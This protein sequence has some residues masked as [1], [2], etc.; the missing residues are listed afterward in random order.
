MFREFIKCIAIGKMPVSFRKFNNLYIT[1][2]VLIKAGLSGDFPGQDNFG[3]CHW[4]SQLFKNIQN[5]I[6]EVI[7]M[8]VR[9]TVV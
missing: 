2:Q 8:P 5:K 3:T 9:E 1:S 6:H 7:H 4:Q